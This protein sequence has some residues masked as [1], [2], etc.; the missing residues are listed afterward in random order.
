ML[1]LPARIHFRAR[2]IRSVLIVAA[3]IAAASTIP[4]AGQ[5]TVYVSSDRSTGGYAKWT[6]RIVDYSGRELRLETPTGLEQRFAAD[7]I[8][9]IETPTSPQ[10]TEA[11]ARLANGEFRSALDLYGDARTAESRLWMRRQIT[12]QMVWCYRG[13]GQLEPAA[14]EFLVLIQSDPATPYFACIPLVWVT[15]E[16]T[17]S[18]ERK[19]RDWLGRSEVPAA[20]LLGASYLMSA[21]SRPQALDCLKRLTGDPD[22]RIAFLALA[23][24]WRAEAV[25]A[26]EK[27]LAAWRDTVERMPEPLR[28]GP[29]YVLGLA[30]AQR[31]RWHEA[32]LAW[33]R[34]PI[35]Y[36]EHRRLAARALLDAGRAL[37]QLGQ[38]PEALRLYQELLTEYRDSPVAGD[39]R[40]RLQA[41]AEREG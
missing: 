8:V 35:L 28:A 3:A 41:A 36:A 11:D 12:A 40:G 21:R 25:T 27:R 17:L 23:Q 34:V 32:A 24:T 6:G 22:Q 19:S 2:A 9:R 26:D 5:D 33:L 39:A 7:Q 20:V 31:Q 13:L 1:A 10:Q 4:A 30:W 16:P 18:L 37:E 29:Y 38:K 14:E 15:A